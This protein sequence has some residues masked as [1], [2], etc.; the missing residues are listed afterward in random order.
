M[1]MPCE[2][3]DGVGTA[4]GQRPPRCRALRRLICMPLLLAALVAHA[5]QRDPYVPARADLVLQ[6]VPPITDPRVRHFEHLRAQLGAHPHDMA[7]AVAL[8]RAYIDYGRSTGDAR[9]LGRAEA[10]IAP[11]MTGPAPPIPVLLVHATIQ[12]SRHYFQA[13][14]EELAQIL[15]RDPQN[16]QAWLT[17]ATVAMVQG[18]YTLANRACVQLANTS[19]D[20]MGMICAASLR[21]LTGHAAQAYTLLAMD[22]DPGPKAPPQIKSWIDGLL[23]DTAARLG[24]ARLAD[25]HYQ[26]ALQQTPG[27]NFLL[28]DYGD[29]LLDQHRPREAL[30]LVADDT[31]SDTSFLR[32]VFAETAL[33]L[34]QARADADEMAARFAALDRRGDHVFDREQASFLLYI[35]KQPQQA[36]AMAEKNWAVQRAPKDVRVYLEAALAAHQPA[37]A[38]PVLA[39]VA[40]THLRDVTIDPLVA[41]LQADTSL[42]DA[43]GAAASAR[44]TQR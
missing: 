3:N 19:G 13:S 29:F 37:A 35:R 21:A 36:L 1:M 15:K 9:Y 43:V 39:F 14:R 7:R 42:A 11:F 41:Q 23:A 40:R 32:R 28:A 26:A 24:R 44:S 12:Q 33:G 30:A 31:A 5:G 18:D 16:V 25:A 2:A 22:E 17:L 8:S 4:H 34:P 6:R 20:F 27:D 10:V 38:A